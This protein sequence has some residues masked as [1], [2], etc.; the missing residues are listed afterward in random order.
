MKVFLLP[1]LLFSFLNTSIGQLFV[2]GSDN[3]PL[4]GAT[5][6]S[7]DVKAADLDSDGDLDIIL[8]NEFQGNTILLNNGNG[9]FSKAPVG[10]LPQ[11]EHDSEDVIVDDFNGDGFLDVIFCSEDDVNLGRNNVYEYYLG[12]IGFVFEPAGYQFPDTEANAV[13]VFDLNG[14]E[15]PDVLFGNNG[16]IGAFVNNGDGS[17]TEESDRFPR[18]HKITQDLL[19]FDADGDGDMDVL[20][21]NENGNLLYINA[22]NGH[23]SEESQDRLPNLNIETRKVSAGDIDADGDMDLFLSN[24][25]FIPGKNREN[26]LLIND[27]TG[28]FTDKTAAQLPADFDHTIDGIF[29]DLDY[30]NDLDIIVSNVFGSPIRFYFNDG[31]G[32]FTELSSRVVAETIFRDALGV[33]AADVNGDDLPDLYFCDRNTGTGNKD[34]LL[35]K[36][37]LTQVRETS[38]FPFL[39]FPSP[40]SNYLRISTLATSEE[41]TMVRLFALSGK[42]LH[43]SERYLPTGLQLANIPDGLYLLQL[44]LEGVQYERLVEINK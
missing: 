26:R 41:K 16:Y 20:E 22:G 7:M 14:D 30:D 42:L 44:E 1:F 24:V 5:G 4:D 37:K 34:V 10:T 9:V 21:G 6:Q 38:D 31:M 11:P 18:I 23:F 35:I 19:A 36:K 40:A 2:N 28:H 8:A 27:G 43:K 39:I 13:I 17:F 25:S 32:F 15:H 12:R 3:L 29:S 33:V